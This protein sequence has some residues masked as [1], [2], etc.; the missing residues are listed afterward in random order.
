MHDLGPVFDA[1]SRVAELDALAHA[2]GL[3][4]PQLWQSMYIFKQ[5]GIGSEVGWHQVL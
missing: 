4:E 1:F 3:Q 5:P 2:L